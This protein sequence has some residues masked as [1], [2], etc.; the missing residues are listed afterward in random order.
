MG[1]KIGQL[2]AASETTQLAIIFGSIGLW[3]LLWA[4]GLV[5]PL[6]T[7]V[8]MFLTI[9]GFYSLTLLLGSKLEVFEEG[10]SIPDEAKPYPIGYD[11]L[12]SISVTHSDHMLRGRYVGTR[13]KFNFGRERGKPWFRYECEYRRG[14]A[15]EKLLEE[16]IRRCSTAIQTKLQ[17]EMN[18]RGVVHWT[19]EVSMS[20][21]GFLLQRSG[22]A[23]PLV[24]AFDQIADVQIRD[25]ELRIWKRGDA[26][27]PFCTLK[28]DTRN[29]VPL[30]DLLCNF[31]S[32]A[33][34]RSE[35]PACH[36]LAAHNEVADVVEHAV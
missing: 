14:D 8:G 24:V 5:G 1:D 15:K 27:V 25:N 34:K 28:N 13:A 21:Q 32:T 9:T 35:T 23:A 4:T 10:F 36:R 3:G 17:N 20:S 2:R 16:L 18:E 12:K 11:E 26:V 7:L 19:D 29:F 30:Y 33:R 22:A 6:L 31:C